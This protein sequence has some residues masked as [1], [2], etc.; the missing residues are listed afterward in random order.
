M[1]LLTKIKTIKIISENGTCYTIKDIKNIKEKFE[2][3]LK[4]KKLILFI[5]DNDEFAIIFYIVCL[6]YKQGLMIINSNITNNSLDSIIKKFKPDIIFSKN[7]KNFNNSKNYKIIKSFEYYNIYQYNNNK[8]LEIHKDLALLL[9]TSGTS[10]ESKFVKLSYQNIYT[11]AEAIKKYLGIKS[12]DRTM[13]ILPIHYSYGISVINSHLVAGAKIFVNKLSFLEKEFWERIKKFKITNF[14]GV[15]FHYEILYKM[16]IKKLPIRNIKVFTQAGG[17]LN[18]NLVKYFTNELIKLKKKFFVM[19]GQT[20]ASPRISYINQKNLRKYP[21]SV[22]KAVPGGA[23]YIKKKKNQVG[24]IYYRGKNI[25][26]GYASDRNHLNDLKKIKILKTGDI[27]YK[28]KNFLFITG[29]I[30]RFI[31]IHGIRLNIDTLEEYLNNL[32]ISCRCIFKNEK[33]YI[34][35]LNMNIDENKIKELINRD[36]EVHTNS[37]KLIKINKF[38]LLTNKKI[39]YKQLSAKI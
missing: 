39:D 6:I 31:K 38:P 21:D 10:G 23:I 18:P 2:S 13:T 17:K 24:E 3:L 19:Y 35:F 33:I 37:I 32:K 15:P 26:C 14:S 36:F 16:N 22:G 8:N 20:E 27:G 34:F 30:S 9:T 4:K 29:R 28:K 11:N 7:S 12:T 25:Y 5:V 1:D